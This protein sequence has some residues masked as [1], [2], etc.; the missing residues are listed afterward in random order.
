MNTVGAGREASYTL[1]DTFENRSS[2][3]G[4][5]RHQLLILAQAGLSGHMTSRSPIAIL[6]SPHVEPKAWIP[7][8]QKQVEQANAA[9]CIA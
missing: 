7:H 5:A 9:R 1:P 3:E 2:S 6:T 4:E 8:A